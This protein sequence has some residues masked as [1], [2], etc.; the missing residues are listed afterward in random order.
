MTEVR[1]A[2]KAGRQVPSPADLLCQPLCSNRTQ[3]IRQQIKLKSQ[4]VS[5]LRIFPHASR[6]RYVLAAKSFLDPRKQFCETRRVFLLSENLGGA[7]QKIGRVCVERRRD[8]IFTRSCPRVVRTRR[9]K[10]QPVAEMKVAIPDVIIAGALALVFHPL[11]HA[12]ILRFED[13]LVT[14]AQ[15]H[16][17]GNDH[18]D[19]TPGS[20]AAG[21]FSWTAQ[22]VRHDKWNAAVLKLIEGHVFQP[23]R[24]ERGHVHVEG[25]SARKDL[26][27]AGPAKTL[28][29]LRA[30]RRDVEKVALLPPKY[31]VLKLID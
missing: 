7:L 10:C 20:G 17:P 11:R 14:I 31:V 1:C 28:V 13:T 18:G 2:D 21:R 29:T 3:F 8:Q 5:S 19:I 30:I 22:H 9:S 24:K 6:L 25:R 16:I 23:L 26:S 4:R 27:V 15:V 12:L